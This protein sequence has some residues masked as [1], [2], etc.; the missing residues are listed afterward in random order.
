MVLQEFFKEEFQSGRVY[1]LFQEKLNHLKQYKTTYSGAIIF[2]Q[3][4]EQNLF[5][6]IG[7]PQFPEMMC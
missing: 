4:M 3:G 7:I 1:A 2:Q 5:T 6:K